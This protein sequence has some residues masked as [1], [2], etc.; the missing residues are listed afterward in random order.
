MIADPTRY[1][2]LCDALAGSGIAAAAGPAG[3]LEAADREVDC[4]MGAIMGAAGLEPTLAAASRANRLAIAN[5]E[6]LVI[7]G[8]LFLAR[9]HATTTEIIPVDSEHAAVYQV[10]DGRAPETIARIV[11]T[12]SGGPFRDW[13][14]ERMRTAMTLRV[15]IEVDAGTGAN[16]LEA[17]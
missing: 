16:W 6:C 12:A 17:H 2:E 15:A 8:E 7:A 13:P 1:G 4:V 5:K 10:I 9:M 14:I 11:L 3:L